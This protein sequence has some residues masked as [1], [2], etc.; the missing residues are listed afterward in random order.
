MFWINYPVFHFYRYYLRLFS[1]TVIN[2]KTKNNLGKKGLITVI[3]EGSQARKLEAGTEAEAI[4][5]WWSLVCSS[6]FAQI[7]VL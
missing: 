2:T 4:E 3:P 7:A 1:F 5:E 6:W